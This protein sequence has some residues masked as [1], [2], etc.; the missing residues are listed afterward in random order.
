MIEYDKILKP[1][2]SNWVH[3]E[4]L[5]EDRVYLSSSSIVR[6]EFTKNRI[7]NLISKHNLNLKVWEDNTMEYSDRF[8]ISKK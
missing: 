5:S 2:I 8:I 4:I 1:L 3:D 7:L 6:K